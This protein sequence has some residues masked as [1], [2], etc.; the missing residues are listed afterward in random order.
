MVHNNLINFNNPKFKKIFKNISW[1]FFDKILKM[2]FGVVIVVL[3]SRYLTPSEFGLYNYTI[4]I[5]SLFAAISALGLNDIVVR[6]LL[7][8][9]RS[10][11]TLGSAFVLRITGAFVG[12]SLLLIAIYVLRPNDENSKYMVLVLSFSI[13]FKSSDTFKSYYESKTASKS[14]V[15]VENTVFIFSSLL[16][17]LMIY[18]K[19]PLII[20]IYLLLLEST[21]IFF[22]LIYVYNRQEKSLLYWEFSMIRSKE[23][24]KDSWPLIISSAAWIIYS[25]MDQVMI[26]QILGN[27]EVGLYAAATNLSQISSFI[28]AII[29]F[30][31]VP[32]IIQFRLSNRNYYNEKFQ[33]IYN[34]VTTILFLLALT[35]TLFSKF[36]INLLYGENY[37]ESSSV[38]TIQFWVVVLIGLAT[39]SG[40][41]LIND[42][43]QKVTMSRH[44]LGVIINIPLNLILIPVYNIEGAAIAS[45]ISLFIVNYVFDM[46]YRK[47]RFI[48]FQKSKALL[49]FW[50]WEKILQIVKK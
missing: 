2:S 9:S 30:S 39:V 41:Y 45:L 34:I 14:V 38:L 43:Y 16:K 18:E 31:I 5:V 8:K 33:V 21:L 47:T 11:T 37:L 49:F 29:T 15:V 35:I 40:R 23:L 42:N 50:F 7:E 4:S 46:F 27:R 48:F 20:F 25:K 44:L 24:L 3:L 13:L 36:I 32:S 10:Y 6:D 19:A 1:L 26:G 28:P 17:L 22:F 12:I